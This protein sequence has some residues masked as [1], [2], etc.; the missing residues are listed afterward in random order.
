MSSLYVHVPFCATR[1]GYC[2]FNT[3]TA[4]EL[5]GGVQRE[6]FHETLIQE[7][8]LRSGQLQGP[9]DTVFFGG[10]TPSLLG[11]PA[12]NA[13]LHAIR[14]AFELSPH[15]EI[16]SEANPDS[17]DQAMLNEMREG[18][19][20]RMSF[21]MQSSAPHVLRVL[22]R[23]HRPGAS[24]QAVA[25]A[26]AA[27]FEHVNLDLIYGTPGETEVDLR[28]TLRDVLDAGV[29]HVSAYALIVE[30]GTALS[31]RIAKGE[32][33]APDDDVAADRY[34]MIDETLHDAG[35]AWYEISNW[36]RPGGECRH[37]LAY[38]RSADWLGIGPGAHSHVQGERW[39]NVKH[40]T[41]YAHMISTGESAEAER[42]VLTEEQ[43]ELEHVMLQ[44]RIREGVRS[45]DLDQDT[46]AELQSADLVRVDEHAHV[47]LTL[48]GRL[49]ADAV[50]RAFMN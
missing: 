6:S 11:A 47:V 49:L 1:C 25:W 42:E 43:R 46:V 18:G 24:T 14:S 9:I 21:G 36:A 16:T 40:P 22:D 20:T 50:A 41:T 23:T 32:I 7:I 29:D 19:F 4:S 5:G 45:A 28:A 13:I 34:L 38:W 31:R 39:W 8:H 44:M 33:A 3:Y 17:V 26:K 27:G 12:L 10:G 15:A 35:L 48:R 30:D 37:N 2:D